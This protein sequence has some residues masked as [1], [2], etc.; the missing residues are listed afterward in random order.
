[1]QMK[2]ADEKHVPADEDPATKTTLGTSPAITKDGPTIT[3]APEPKS[4]QT[5]KPE[6]NVQVTQNSGQL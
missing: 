2:G 4:V 1:M 3:P 5:E 6:P